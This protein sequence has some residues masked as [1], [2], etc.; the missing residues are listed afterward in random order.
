M[1]QKKTGKISSAKAVAEKIRNHAKHCYTHGETYT[2]MDDIF[3]KLVLPIIE[4]ERK[5]AKFEGFMEHHREIN[6]MLDGLLNKM[7]EW[8]KRDEKREK[9]Q[10]ES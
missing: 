5:L 10:G 3:I 1:T 8:R 4:R 2:T 6:G 9:R 7:E